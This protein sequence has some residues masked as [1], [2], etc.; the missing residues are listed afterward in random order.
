MGWSWAPTEEE[1]EEQEVVGP[2]IS[3]DLSM[4]KPEVKRGSVHALFIIRFLNEDDLGSSFAENKKKS[5]ML[6]CHHSKLPRFD[7][8]ASA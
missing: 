5:F 8:W 6:F 4:P 7:G 3:L 1:E 2:A